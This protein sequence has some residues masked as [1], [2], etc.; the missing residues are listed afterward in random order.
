M[1][2]IYSRLYDVVVVGGGVAGCAAAVSAA[3]EGALTIVVEQRSCLGG[4]LTG[5]GVGPMMSFH[6]GEEQVIEGFMQEVVDRLAA[7][8]ASP[9]HV[10]DTKQYVRY[11]TPFNAEALKLVLDGMADES[12]CNVLLNTFSGAVEVSGG[13]IKCVTVCNK[14]GLNAV[15]GKVFIDATGDADIAA[16]AG[17]PFEMGREEDGAS[18]PMTLMMKYAGV[19]TEELKRHV[20]G[21][22]EEFPHMASREGLLKLD[23]PMDLEGFHREVAEAKANGELSIARENILMFM[24]DRE[25]E[26]I[27]NTTRVIDH[28]PTDAFSLSDAE[29]QGRRQCAQLDKVLRQKV[30]G[31]SKAILEFTGPSIGV[32][33][34]R[35]IKGRHVL[36]AKDILKRK[37]FD[38]AIAF[39]GYPIDIH[40]PKG[41]GAQARFIE[42][43]SYGVPFEVMVCD[44]AS[45]LLVAGR[46]VSATFEAQ[47]AVRVSPTAG[48]M[49]QAAGLAAYL[50]AKS[51]EDVRTLAKQTQRLA[52]ERGAALKGYDA[53]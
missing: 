15:K 31:F 7:M 50:S 5:C 26:F 33:S 38:T 46:C 42:G 52:F 45:N 10:L 22:M 37:D 36:T 53:Q 1:K 13:A 43:G 25:G 9:G 6:A 21:H 30:P 51:G 48:A 24:T 41:E 8:G 29:K 12:G 32:R 11:I 14:D 19:D 47:A 39:S 23:I 40:N 35:Q 20:L 17:V 49:G 28:D 44:E 18:Q 34:S 2:E 16:W 4:T 3:R 27:I